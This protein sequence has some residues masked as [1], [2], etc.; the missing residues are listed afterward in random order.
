M[1]GFEGFELGPW[2]DLVLAGLWVTVYATVLGTL[3]AIVVAFVLGLLSLHGAR[4]AAHFRPRRGRVLPRHL[5]GGPAVL[6]RLRPAGD[7]RLQ[8]R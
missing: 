4:A 3:L 5:A 7:H 8:D 1:E 2:M 6:D